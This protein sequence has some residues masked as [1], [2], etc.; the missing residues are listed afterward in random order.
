MLQKLH[1]PSALS[2]QF[3]RTYDYRLP[4]TTYQLEPPVKC[5]GGAV[6]SARLG[7]ID[8]P[9]ATA[10]FPVLVESVSGRSA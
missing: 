5:A 2:G 4:A 6:E 3:L 8:R 1:T 7:G 10:D 9:V